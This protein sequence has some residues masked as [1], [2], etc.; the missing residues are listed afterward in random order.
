M[1]VVKLQSLRTAEPMVLET[2]STESCTATVPLRN[3]SSFPL[4]ISL[5]PQEHKDVFSVVPAVITIQPHSQVSPS[6]VFSPRGQLGR[7]ERL[8][9]LL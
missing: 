7:M 9:S 6:L 1:G 5:V 8:V 4:R 2:V 3:S